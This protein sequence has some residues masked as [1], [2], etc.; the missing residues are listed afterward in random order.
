MQKKFAFTLFF[1]LALSV[2]FYPLVAFAAEE[3]QG[4][5]QG[6]DSAKSEALGECIVAIYKWAL[7]FSVI[8]AL[9]MIIFAGYLY[10]TSGGNA[11][12]V[13]LAKE[14]FAGAII[15]LIVLFCA[16]IILRTINPEL[17][18]FNDIKSLKL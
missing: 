14:F 7:G 11:Q 15:G 13:T 18:N 5:C 10:M 4:P 3:S 9:L 17:V 8:L 12:R 1:L 2:T 16:I 6:I